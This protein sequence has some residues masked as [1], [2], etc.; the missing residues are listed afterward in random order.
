MTATS[1]S[2]PI[3]ADA[4][5]KRM[6][7]GALQADELDLSI[8]EPDQPMAQRLV[9]AAAASLNAGRTGYTPKLGL[10]ELRDAV[11]RD[12][13]ESTGYA[14][15]AADVVITAGGTEAVSVALRAACAHGDLIVIPDPAWPNYR[16]V[17]EHH[18][19]RVMTYV[20]GTS[21]DG[22]FDIDAIGLALTAG[23]RLVIVNSPS[24]PVGTVASRAALDR[25]VRLVREHRALILSDEAYES[26]VFAGG[27]AVS[28]LEMGA[29]LTFSARTFSKTYSMTG[30]RV[31]SL[32]SPVAFREAV[33]AIHGTTSGC[34]PITGQIVA[35][36][37]L[38]ET[39]GDS[40]HLAAAYSRRHEAAR[41]ILGRWMPI[42]S[43]EHFGGFYAWLD[44]SSTG[45]SG[46][47]LVSEIRAEGVV[48]TDGRVFSPTADSALRIALTAPDAILLP[49]L[50]RIAAV[51]DQ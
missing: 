22:F 50:E 15:D 34:A 7:A 14:P 2:A 23:A 26:V 5:V 11:A 41:A 24:N 6:M 12:I 10:D 18:G 1:A 43:V 37:A 21:G 25:V 29:D 33:A 47:V 46:E 36:A 13:R 27:R 8:G 16:V 42:D 40:E 45:R 9:Q 32:V 38:S 28:P 17:A 48:V 49:A 35:L 20:Q 4:A 3:S 44:T 31:G 19:L 51:L 30:M 39:L